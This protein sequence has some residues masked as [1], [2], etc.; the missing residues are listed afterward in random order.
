MK[1]ISKK[2]NKLTILVESE[3]YKGLHEKIG[4]GKIS[5]YINDKVKP[6]VT[7]ENSIS[8]SYAEMAKD[9]SRE[10][11][12]KEWITITEDFNTENSW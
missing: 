7:N 12:A 9:S 1:T 8:S 4:R 11:N 6:F 10:T 3:V 5:K 2:K